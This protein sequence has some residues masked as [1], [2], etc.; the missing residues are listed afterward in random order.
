MY[1]QPK[2]LLNIW[3]P[4]KNHYQSVG[5]TQSSYFFSILVSLSLV[6]GWESI[7]DS[8]E[9]S[10]IAHTR[11]TSRVRQM[12]RKKL[13]FSEREPMVLRHWGRLELR[14]RGYLV[15]QGER[16]RQTPVEIPFLGLLHHKWF[17]SALFNKEQIDRVDFNTHLDWNLFSSDFQVEME[18]LT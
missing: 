15:F 5:S 9:Y 4:Y 18:E 7:R 10:Y 17:I 16:R 13:S 11:A 12:S 14:L 3:R 1:A 8:A 6:I 2:R